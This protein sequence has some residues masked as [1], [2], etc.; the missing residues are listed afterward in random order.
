MRMSLESSYTAQSWYSSQCMQCCIICWRVV[1]C[2]M[3]HG[4]CGSQAWWVTKHDPLS[5]LDDTS[6]QQSA[7]SAKKWDVQRGLTTKSQLFLLWNQYEITINCWNECLTAKCCITMK[8]PYF[9]PSCR[10]ILPTCRTSTSASGAWYTLAF[11][12]PEWPICR[13]FLN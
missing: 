3:G 6:R 8:H 7:A 9:I 12:A 1:K 2:T 11:T 13:C 5:S 4:S 10:S